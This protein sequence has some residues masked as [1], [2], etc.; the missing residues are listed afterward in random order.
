M[1]VH[2]DYAPIGVDE[3]WTRL[4]RR[5]AA[6]SPRTPTVTWEQLV[7]WEGYFQHP[8]EDELA[9]FDPP[10]FSDHAQEA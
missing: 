4:Q 5:N 10:L 8:S 9:L 1:A 2:L 7:E 6:L 3:L